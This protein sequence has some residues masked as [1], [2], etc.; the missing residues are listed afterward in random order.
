MDKEGKVIE[1]IRKV[2]ARK[3]GKGKGGNGRILSHR[4]GEE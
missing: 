1:K 4:E 3:G 2:M